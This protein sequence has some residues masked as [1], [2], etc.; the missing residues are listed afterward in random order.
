MLLLHYINNYLLTL[1]TYKRPPC[2][3]LC[4]PVDA[5]FQLMHPLHV[6]LLLESVVCVAH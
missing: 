6:G 3:A 2:L 4:P 5:D 1:L